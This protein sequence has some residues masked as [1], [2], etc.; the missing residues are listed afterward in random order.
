MTYLLLFSKALVPQYGMMAF[1]ALAEATQGV[2]DK[3]AAYVK[4]ATGLADYAMQSQWR[5]DVNYGYCACSNGLSP[6]S[7]R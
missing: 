1:A 3:H 4:A 7:P 5:R 2:P 6:L